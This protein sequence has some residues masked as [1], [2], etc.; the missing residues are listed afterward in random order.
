MLSLVPPMTPRQRHGVSFSDVLETDELQM[1]AA[2]Y[3]SSP[4]PA[5]ESPF[6]LFPPSSSSA[7]QLS[8][9]DGRALFV[10]GSS[11]VPAPGALPRGLGPPGLPLVYAS[12]HTHLLKQANSAP[13]NMGYG[14]DC[15]SCSYVSFN[16][17]VSLQNTQVCFE[18]SCPSFEA[19]HLLFA[20]RWCDTMTTERAVRQKHVHKDTQ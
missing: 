6:D 16:K 18:V 2:A 14:I 17:E 9:A 15:V 8:L 10:P 12:L 20:C 19:L 3:V 1:I 4:G 13:A 7:L 5:E 11:S